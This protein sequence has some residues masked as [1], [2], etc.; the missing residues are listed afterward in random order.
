MNTERKVTVATRLILSAFVGIIALSLAAPVQAEPLTTEIPPELIEGTPMP[1]KVP[2][3]VPA[4]KKMPSLNVP[5]GTVLLSKGKPVTGSDDF[6]II[7]EL[8]YITDGDKLGGEG[9]FVE[10]MDGVQWIQIDLEASAEIAAIWIWHFHSQARAYH[11]VIVQVSDDEEFASGVK[12]LYNNDYDN[13][14]G[15]G[16]GSDKSYVESRFGLLV[17]GKGS[18]GRYVRLYSAGN[19]S[20]D[21]NHYI[22]VEVFGK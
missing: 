2:N 3:L 13:S 17:D 9:Y 8:E 1:I 19:T 6:P 11:D 15:L 16:K 4:P 7:G 21:M 10:L 14:A 5:A 22:E 20:N 12:T 18:K